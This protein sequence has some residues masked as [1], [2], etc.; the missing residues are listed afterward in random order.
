[1]IRSGYSK[2][3]HNG[4]HGQLDLDLR[5]VELSLAEVQLDR[6]ALPVEHQ[7]RRPAGIRRCGT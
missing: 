7:L 3:G 5:M 4:I 2:P 1:M 6:T